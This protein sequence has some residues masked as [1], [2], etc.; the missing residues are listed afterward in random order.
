[1]EGNVTLGDNGDSGD[2][3]VLRYGPL[4][5]KHIGLSDFGHADSFG[6]FIK[7]LKAGFK[8]VQD[9]GVALT[10]IQHDMGSVSIRSIV[11]FA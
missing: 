11:H 1:M 8:V 9:T 7:E 5:S 6:Q 4:E 3:L 10:Q 2:A